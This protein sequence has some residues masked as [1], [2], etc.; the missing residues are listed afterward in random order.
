M[1]FV[2]PLPMQEKYLNTILK[3][4]LNDKYYYRNNCVKFVEDNFSSNLISKKYIEL[5]KKTINDI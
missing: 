4:V 5:Y 1:L 2:V 3:N